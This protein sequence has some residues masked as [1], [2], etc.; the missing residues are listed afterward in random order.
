MSMLT[1]GTHHPYIAPDSY[2][3]AANGDRKAASIQ[4]L[5]DII[6]SFVAELQTRGVLDDT[7]VIFTSDESHGVPGHPFGGN[8][9][10]F[11]A[12]GAGISGHTQSGVFGQVD[13]ALSVLD[14]L[15]LT[16]TEFVF[17]G[18][19]VFRENPTPRPMLFGK[20]FSDSSRR[21]Y[22]CA[23]DY[24]DRYQSSGDNLFASSYQLSALSST[25]ADP[26]V[27]KKRALFARAGLFYGRGE[28]S[29]LVF[30]ENINLPLVKQQNQTWQLQLPAKTRV[31]VA[32]E[33][34]NTGSAPAHF[35]TFW[36]ENGNIPIKMPD[37]RLP[38][39]PAASGISLNYSFYNANARNILLGLIGLP[40]KKKTQA[41]LRQIKVQSLPSNNESFDVSHFS[42]WS[43][44]KQEDDKGRDIF[45]KN[46]VSSNANSTNPYL[47]AT[48]QSS[49]KGDSF[50]APKYYFGEQLDFSNNGPWH[51][52]LALATDWLYPEP[53]GIWSNGEKPA[54]VVKLGDVDTDAEYEMRIKFS[55]YVNPPILDSQ[56]LTFFVNQKRLGQQTYNEKKYNDIGVRIPGR[57]LNAN[58]LNSFSIGVQTPFNPSKYN[59]GDGFAHLGVGIVNFQLSRVN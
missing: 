40:H 18:R 36:L 23:A 34:E 32:L 5:D 11:A 26:F 53:W 24:C 46:T 57:L 14:Y 1:V 35:Y 21:I 47:I 20:F 8:W 39:V 49:T 19:S 25:A 6:A 54:L 55:P 51:H 29:V 27:A 17:L 58:T 52:R 56:T 44:K 59:A 38:P 4:Y 33:V 15:Q 37:V 43:H 7:L 41:N 2:I 3:T 31:N 28:N 50:I 30:E 48:H 12:L 42:L 22:F 10:L 16:K 13:I 45:S 9:G